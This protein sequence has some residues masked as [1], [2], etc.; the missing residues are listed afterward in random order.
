MLGC[1]STSCMNSWALLEW[2]RN[3]QRFFTW[4]LCMSETRLEAATIHH[5]RTTGNRRSLQSMIAQNGFPL[6][7]DGLVGQAG[8][9]PAVRSMCLQE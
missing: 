2:F 5:V 9:M 1:C 6:T 3:A 7:I 8:P 4:T